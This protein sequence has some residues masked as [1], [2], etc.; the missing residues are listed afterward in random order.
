M[1]ALTSIGA[2]KLQL[3]WDDWFP[4]PTD[5]DI[6]LKKALSEIRACRTEL[7]AGYLY[8]AIGNYV[9]HENANCGGAVR[10]STWNCPHL[11]QDTRATKFTTGHSSIAVCAFQE[12][13][14]IAYLHPGIKL[15]EGPDE[16]LRWWTA[17][18]TINELPAGRMPSVFCAHSCLEESKDQQIQ[19]GAQTHH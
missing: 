19:M 14:P 17:A 13:G 3:N 1:I 18:I 15:P 2:R 4:E 16:D 8:P 7:S 6:A 11:I 12:R 9:A 10:D 5:F